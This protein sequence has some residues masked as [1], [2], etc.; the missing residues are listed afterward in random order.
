MLLYKSNDRNFSSVLEHHWALAIGELK[1][2][3]LTQ[4]R[5]K[6]VKKLVIVLLPWQEGRKCWFLHVI[7]LFLRQIRVWN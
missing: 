2:E 5:M 3:F 7:P 4:C 6:K 1:L